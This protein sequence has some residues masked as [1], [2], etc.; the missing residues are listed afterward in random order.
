MERDVTFPDLEARRCSEVNQARW[1]LAFIDRLAQH[2]YHEVFGHLFGQVPADDTAGEPILVSDQVADR[3]AFQGCLY[4]VPAPREMPLGQCR[5]DS[6]I[7]RPFP[8]SMAA[9]TGPTA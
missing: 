7:S 4:I 1:R 3:S 9:S 5:L 8:T 2:G 6:E